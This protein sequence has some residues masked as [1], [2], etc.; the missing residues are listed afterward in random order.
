M[1]AS[2][3]ELWRP[4]SLPDWMPWQRKRRRARLLLNDL[5]ERHLQARL[6]MPQEDW[7]DDLLAR[8]LRL[9]SRQPRDW[10]LQAVRDECKTAFLAGHETIAASL[11]WW[12]WCM[13][14]HPDIQEKARADATA[15]WPGEESGEPDVSALHYVSQTLQET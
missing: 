4:A 10:P 14:S 3:A 15:A 7:P 12:A 5:I 6:G 1:V 11:G 9:H 8:L 2:T 13:A